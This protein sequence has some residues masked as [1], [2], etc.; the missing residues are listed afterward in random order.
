MEVVLELALE[1]MKDLVLVQRMELE[2]LLALEWGRDLVLEY[3]LELAL[4]LEW[5]LELVV[6]SE[7]VWGVQ[8]EVSKQVCVVDFLVSI[9]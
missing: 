7:F 1:L 4:A 8:V 2:Q 9:F 6:M 3:G 5:G